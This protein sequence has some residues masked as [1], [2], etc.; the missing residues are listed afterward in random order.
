MRAMVFRVKSFRERLCGGCN[1]FKKSKTLS[2][3][4]NV[5]YLGFKGRDLKKK[6]NSFFMTILFSRSKVLSVKKL[7]ELRIVFN[8]LVLKP[9]LYL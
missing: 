6:R 9:W 4:Q 3:D 2:T 8:E 7:M 1:V 5:E